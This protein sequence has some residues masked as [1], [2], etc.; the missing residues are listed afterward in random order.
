MS[1]LLVEGGD[2]DGHPRGQLAGS[3][4]A[5][6]V[7]AVHVR[8][9][10]D[11]RD[12]DEDQVGGVDQHEVG[13]DQGRR[14][15]EDELE[16]LVDRVVGPGPGQTATPLSR[17]RASAVPAAGSSSCSTTARRPRGP[18][19]MSE[20]AAASAICER[21]SSRWRVS[22][23]TAASTPSSPSASIAACRTGNGK[24]GSAAADSA[25]TS[26]GRPTLPSAAAAAAA[27]VGSLVRLQLGDE[28]RGGRT[29]PAH[30]AQVG[31]HGSRPRVPVCQ[32][33]E[34]GVRDAVPHADQA[35]RGVTEAHAL[36]PQ[37]VHNGLAA[38]GSPIW[39]TVRTA[40][41]RTRRDRSSRRVDGRVEAGAAPAAAD[42]VQRPDPPGG[43]WAAD[44][45]HGIPEQ[46]VLAQ[47]LD[48]VVGRFPTH[49]ADHLDDEV[50][51]VA[52]GASGDGPEPLQR[53]TVLGVL[54]R[55]DQDDHRA[56]RRQMTLHHPFAQPPM[57][58]HPDHRDGHGEAR[59]QCRDRGQGDQPGQGEGR[60]HALGRARMP[61]TRCTSSRG[62][63]GLTT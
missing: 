21:G 39:P 34:Q 48:Q 5:A 62:L 14:D 42:E 60:G 36:P 13:Q 22:T 41:P 59:H 23:G 56:Q 32:G 61:L 40:W 1:G 57:A 12:D 50:V 17:A 43:Q 4:L 19:A 10:L 15:G 28:Q 51:Q 9:E 16:A 53:H 6:G 44:P 35:L 54:P 30:A 27:T 37:G 7:L 63:N 38:R 3:L 31:G 26:C 8:P 49:L 20:R 25:P 24:K 29:D 58:L 2:D 33:V 46:P 45:A 11:G 52:S 18:R 47:E 55:R